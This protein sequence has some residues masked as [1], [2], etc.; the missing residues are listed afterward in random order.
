MSTNFNGNILEN[1]SPDRIKEIEI[2]WIDLLM[3]DFYHARLCDVIGHQIVAEFGFKGK[4][5]KVWEQLSEYNDKI[6]DMEFTPEFIAELI[7]RK[8]KYNDFATGTKHAR[9]AIVDAIKS[10]NLDKMVNTTNLIMAGNQQ[11][12]ENEMCLCFNND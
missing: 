10:R 3:E 5:E 9:Q 7:E 2:E 1:L 4:K 6:Q 8:K 11:L 12:H